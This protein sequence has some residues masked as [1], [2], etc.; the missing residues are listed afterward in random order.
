MRGG[1]LDDLTNLWPSY[2]LPQTVNGITLEDAGDGWL[3]AYGT[4]TAP[5]KISDFSTTLTV[6]AGTYLHRADYER[7]SSEIQA[8]YMRG[9]NLI[10]VG[11]EWAEDV[12]LNTYSHTFR[13]RTYGNV[14]DARVR[15]F[16]F[17]IS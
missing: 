3:H 14:I 11:E 7:R 10:N 1:G 2:D 6:E 17:K 9:G 13:I 15:P 8:Q 5:A 12:V 4:S 16:L